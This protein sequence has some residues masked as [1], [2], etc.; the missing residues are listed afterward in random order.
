MAAGSGEAD[1]PCGP[2]QMRQ[3]GGS[4]IHEKEQ[5]KAG[6]VS[7]DLRHERSTVFSEDEAAYIM[8]GNSMNHDQWSTGLLRDRKMQQIRQV[9]VEL[10]R[11]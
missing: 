7:S 3:D 11:S 9:L 10:N 4:V 8:R 2:S 6:A 1:Q 5:T